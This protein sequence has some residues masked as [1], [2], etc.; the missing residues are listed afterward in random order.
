MPR[1]D[2]ES[3]AVDATPTAAPSE[4]LSATAAGDVN[5]NADGDGDGHDGDNVYSAA[6]PTDEML[7]EAIREAVTAAANSDTIT[8]KHVRFVYGHAVGELG[9]RS[10]VCCYSCY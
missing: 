6:G 7:R 3:F 10:C 2:E 4:V 1:G 5:G 9:F 8:P